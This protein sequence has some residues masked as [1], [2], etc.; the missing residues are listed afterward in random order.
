MRCPSGDLQMQRWWAQ[1]IRAAATPST[2]RALIDMNSAVDVRDVLAA[3]RVPTLVLHRKEDPLFN[4]A[5]AR[6]LG[7]HIP[8]ATLRLLDGADHL[9]CG[10][11][12]Q[13][14]DGIEEFLGAG[15]PDRSQA[16]SLA[17]VVAVTGKTQSEVIESLSAR[18]G[19]VRATSS[20]RRVVLFDGPATAIRCGL[21][22]L[23]ANTRLGVSIGEVARESPTVD[24]P[25]V[26]QAIRIA[27]VAEAGAIWVSATAGMLV[28]GSGIPLAETPVDDDT[29]GRPLLQ[30]LGM[31]S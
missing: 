9:P 19:L 27:E 16:L 17:A 26:E 20:G 25:G 5:E 23:R 14:L 24:G 22:G 29:V 12:D 11:P 18:G 3:V 6:Y 10:D 13:I 8:G 28:A 4:V 15:N 30:V 1:R 31:T 21:A 2:I 7:D